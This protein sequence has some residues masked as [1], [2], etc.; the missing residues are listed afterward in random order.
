MQSPGVVVNSSILRHGYH[1]VDGGDLVKG[2]ALR[3]GEVSIW[4]PDLGRH[5]VAERQSFWI[6][7]FQPRVCPKLPDEEVQP[8]VLLQEEIR[9]FKNPAAQ[10]YEWHEIE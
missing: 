3:V 2:R 6:A 9:E 7:V 10:W 8:V 4:Y 5:G 1:F